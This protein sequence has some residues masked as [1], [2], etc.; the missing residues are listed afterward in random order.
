APAPLGDC[1]AKPS[2][3]E[4]LR[5]EELLRGPLGAGQSVD[6]VEMVLRDLRER[7]IRRR[8]DA[9]DSSKH[10]VRQTRTAAF[11][12]NRYGQKPGELELAQFLP[13]D[14]TLCVD[15][16]RRPGPRRGQGPRGR[17]S[18]FGRNEMA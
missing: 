5:V 15:G 6:E 17:Q 7:R 18:I 16:G 9:K 1:V 10:R 2:A 12:R 11:P 14:A 8:K 3:G 4:N 13:G